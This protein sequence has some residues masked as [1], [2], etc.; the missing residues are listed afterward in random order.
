L[1]DVDVVLQERGRAVVPRTV[2][3]HF[4]SDGYVVRIVLTGGPCAGKSSALEHLRMAATSR[5]FDVM[6]APEVATVIFN[7]GYKFPLPT[8]ARFEAQRLEFQA[9]VARLQ[10]QM[11]R[12]LLALVALTGRPTIMVYDRGVLDGKGYLNDEEWVQLVGK[13]SDS[14]GNP[15]NEQYLLDR[16]GNARRTCRFSSSSLHRFLADALLHFADG[17]IHLVTAADGAEEFYKCGE[18]VD[19]SGHAVFRRE[20]AE[21]ARALDL[22]MQRCYAG[23]PRSVIVRNTPAGFSQKLTDATNAVLRIAEETH[24][25]DSKSVGDVPEDVQSHHRSRA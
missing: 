9:A 5:G 8:E 14:K 24:P 3:K 4:D 15:V 2:V 25:T 20:T 6:T 17:V 10:L 12:N 11:E 22:L 7:S 16:Y 23:H 18:I 13:L 19:D 1:H 21:E